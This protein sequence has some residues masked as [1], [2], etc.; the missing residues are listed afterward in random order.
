[1]CKSQRFH[2]EQMQ[3]IW[4]RDFTPPTAAKGEKSPNMGDNRSLSE[5]CLHADPQLSFA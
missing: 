3:Q 4:F 2:S 1:M 5:E